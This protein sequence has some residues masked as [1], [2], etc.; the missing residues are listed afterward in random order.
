LVVGDSCF[1]GSPRYWSDRVPE[2][3]GRGGFLIFPRT[4]GLEIPDLVTYNP[5][6]IND[7]IK[8]I[9]YWLD[10]TRDQER[11]EIV[12]KTQAWVKENETYT[13]RMK[14]VLD[15]MGIK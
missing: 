6:D 5:G 4:P 15:Y 3:L 12:K 10:E 1:A 13:Q 14:F 11:K 2:V 7:L 9:D 8:K